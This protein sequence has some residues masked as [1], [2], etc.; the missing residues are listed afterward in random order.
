MTL[1]MPGSP[2]SIIYIGTPALAVPPLRALVEAGYSVPLVITR[3]DAARG[4]GAKLLP[5]HVKA[6]AIRLGL[7]V[8]HDIAD[9]KTTPADLGVVV[10]Y[11]QI[12]PG[13]VLDVLP[14]VN[15]H[16]SLLPRWRGAAPVERALLAC[17]QETGVCLMDVAEGLDEGDVYASRVVPIGPWSTLE[18]LRDELV[19]TGT[20]LLLDALANG[21]AEP[22]AQQG[23]SIYATKV[24]SDDLHLD[25][26]APAA[27]VRGV[28][29]VGG[30]W[31]TFRGKRFKVHAIGLA[32]GDSVG[33]PPG[34]LAP[35]RA[36]KRGP[37]VATADA[38]LELT[39]VQP[40]GKAVMA[41]SQ[42]VAG[43]RLEP[44]ERFDVDVD[45]VS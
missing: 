43:A 45:A 34:T 25:F 5:S 30:A 26:G 19:H 36:K 7:P 2:K 37:M 13:A 33:T 40:E 12:I 42:W 38:W 14:M 9:A 31:T 15:L 23:P 27:T 32:E 11:G 35:P 21:F 24:S 1:P 8:S 16:F 4:R 22:V 18:S 17:D 44:G 39:E 28:V 20:D 41:G 3:P 29:A 6:E 10:A